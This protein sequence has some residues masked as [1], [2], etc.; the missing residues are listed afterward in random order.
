MNRIFTL[1]IMV[2]VVCSIATAQWTHRGVWPPAGQVKGDTL[3][4]G[5]VH[6]LAVSPD[7]KVWVQDYYAYSRDSLYVGANQNKFIG[8]RAL[9][10]FNKDGTQASFSPIKI[11]TIAG[12][13]DTLGGFTTA[14]GTW[15][16]QTGR[17]LRAD[18]Q[19]NIIATYYSFLYRINYQTGAGMRKVDADPLNSGISVGVDASGNIFTNRV[20]AGGKPLKIFDKDFNFIGNAR[21]TLAGFSRAIEVSK[22]GNDIY[23]AGYTNHAVFKYHSDFGV[24]GPYAKVDTI[25]KGFDAESF[26]WNPKTG[27]LWVSAGSFNDRPNRWWDTSV[28]QTFTP[29][30]WYAYN[31]TTGAIQDSINWNFAVPGNVGERPRAIAFSPGGDTAYVGTFGTFA[32][33]GLRMYT[34]GVAVNVSRDDAGIP[35][36]FT[37]SQNYPNPFNPT[38]D[39]RFTIAQSGP[40]QLVI[41]DMLGREMKTV[42]DKYLSPGTYTATVDGRDMTSGVYVYVLTSGGHRLSGKMVLSK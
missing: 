29:G 34:R 9:Y 24:L 28:P 42:L 8:V 7:G 20:V 12:R 41:Y 36:G 31:V 14:T 26:C 23:Y 18:H 30:T 38:T 33:P 10:A 19:G 17:G 6:G 25:L 37:L 2:L 22:N 35:E 3:F 16:A 21:D 39:I 11:V 13:A 15:E 27:H 1:I 32:V 4:T 5:N 40:T